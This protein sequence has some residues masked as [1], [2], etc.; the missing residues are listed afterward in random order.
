[1]EDEKRWKRGSLYVRWDEC[2]GVNVMKYENFVRKM[3][4]KKKNILMK[5]FHFFFQIN[6]EQYQNNR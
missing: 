4:R 6:N 2:V 3:R 5:K 1:M